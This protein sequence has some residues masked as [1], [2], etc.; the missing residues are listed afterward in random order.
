MP[1]Q[2]TIATWA[3]HCCSRSIATGSIVFRFSHR[4]GAVDETY[5]FW[6]ISLLCFFSSSHPSSSHPSSSHSFSS[7][8]ISPLDPSSLSISSATWPSQVLRVALLLD[9]PHIFQTL[10]SARFSRLVKP[11]NISKRQKASLYNNLLHW[12]AWPIFDPSIEF[13]ESIFFLLVVLAAWGRRRPRSLPQP[14]HAGSGLILP[15]HANCTFP[16]SDFRASM[17]NFEFSSHWLQ[18]GWPVPQGPSSQSQTNILEPPRP[19]KT[20]VSTTFPRH[21]HTTTQGFLQDGAQKKQGCAGP[22]C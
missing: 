20:R 15:S 11:P 2:D 22:D 5:L 17:R 10:P 14:E 8:P 7:H 18:R 19:L 21:L 4:A 3:G 9:Q 1:R 12:R 6:L 13:G 16:R